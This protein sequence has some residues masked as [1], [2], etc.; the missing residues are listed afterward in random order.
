[1]KLEEWS[2]EKFR[3]KWIDKTI[4]KKKQKQNGNVKLLFHDFGCCLKPV[5][6]FKK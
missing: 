4:V 2:W 5:Y 1:M 6:N 3:E